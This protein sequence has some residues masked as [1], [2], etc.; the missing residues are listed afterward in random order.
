[1][2]LPKPKYQKATLSLSKLGDI[3]F[4]SFKDDRVPLLHIQRINVND[5]VEQYNN[6][7][8][9]TLDNHAPVIPIDLINL[10][11]YTGDIHVDRRLHRKY[12]RQRQKSKLEFYR[13][14]HM[15][16]DETKIVNNSI[17]EAEKNYFTSEFENADTKT[18]SKKFNILLNRGAKIIP[19]HESTKDLCIDFAKFFREKVTK[20]TGVSQKILRRSVVLIQSFQAPLSVIFTNLN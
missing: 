2:L 6:A 5:L 19:D 14:M 17:D 18:I 16:V 4:P 3:D 20:L 8:K 12:E 1:M 15:Y 13:Q 9:R 7:L 10:K 11:R